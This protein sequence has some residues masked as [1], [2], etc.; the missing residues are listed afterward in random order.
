MNAK[1]VKMTGRMICEYLLNNNK[2]GIYISTIEQKGNY[3]YLKIDKNDFISKYESNDETLFFCRVYIYGD[4]FL[5]SE[6]N[7][8]LL[9]K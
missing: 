2:N 7:F 1:Y 3:N 9:N 6:D 4:I 5:L 8:N